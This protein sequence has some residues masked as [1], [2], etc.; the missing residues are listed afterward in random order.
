MRTRVPLLLHIGYH[1]TASTWLQS[2]LFDDPRQ[3]F[4]TETGSPRHALVERLVVPDP[5]FYDPAEAAAGYRRAIRLAADKGCTLVLSHE[6]LSGYPSSGGRDRQL[7][8]E[9]LAGTFPGAH[10]LI[11]IREQK[12]VI[13]SMYSQHVTD[14]GV[15]SITRFLSTPEPA[16]CRKPTFNLGYYCYDRLIALYHRLFGQ[17]R[18]LVLPYELLARDPHAFSASIARHCRGEASIPTS[19][20][21]RVN[22]ARPLIMQ[23]VQRPL[24]MLFYH[25][26]LSPG[27]LLHIPRFHKRFARL[28]P[29]FRALSPSIV[30]RRL[31]ARL[32]RIIAARVGNHYLESNQRT[33][34]FV[35]HDLA[36][37]GYEVEPAA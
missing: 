9:R 35:D 16:L 32:R 10:V 11:V 14:G 31:D 4:T 6:R 30:E 25:N 22:T 15:E 20:R 2:N 28:T 3:G 12:A 33:Q 26:E 36:A 37:L 17:E 19:A 5:L 1:K 8:A 7:L 21:E 24:N 29:I 23:A 34:A 18:V 13:R 27:A